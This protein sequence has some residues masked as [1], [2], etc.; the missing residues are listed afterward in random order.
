[1]A[2]LAQSQLRSHYS[3]ALNNVLVAGDKVLDRMDADQEHQAYALDRLT[4][5]IEILR[6]Q[7]VAFTQQLSS[8]DDLFSAAAVEMQAGY[9][10]V[11]AGQGD[12]SI[13]TTA[14]DNLRAEKRERATD[15]VEPL[16]FD[17][18]LLKAPAESDTDQKALDD[19]KQR[20]VRTLENMVKEADDVF[21]SAVVQF[22]KV[23]D[24]FWKSFREL[25][26]AF[27]AA[28][29]SGINRVGV[30]VV[31]SSLKRLDEVFQSE[32]L[33]EILAGLKDMVERFNLKDKMQQILESIFGYAET[34]KH[35]DSLMLSATVNRATLQAASIRMA[36]LSRQY[37]SV[38]KQVRRVLTIVGA[39][40]GLLVVAGAAHY[41][42]LGLPVAYALVALATL[43]IG[44][45]FAESRMRQ[46][47][48][49]M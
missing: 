21:S 27:A 41:A 40:G 9:V 17:V 20:G 37:C 44:L 3:G 11:A 28:Q 47:I 23:F 2:S 32:R 22:E 34:K 36:D 35:I 16:R 8:P 15:Q 18:D 42:T 7:T 12:R 31:I 19:F 14:L 46:I 26:N 24:Q 48:F 33:D 43:L 29:D 30:E 38:L 4:D 39:M 13:I 25:A 1:M 45:T 49:S 10:L 6:Q 5:A